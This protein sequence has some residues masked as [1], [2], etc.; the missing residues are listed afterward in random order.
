MTV[1]EMHIAFKFRMDKLD[2]LNY[3]DFEPIEIDLLLNQAQDRFV[4]QRYG[5]N[6]IKRQSFEESQKRTD[7]LRNL[8]VSAAITPLPTTS[9]NKPNGVFI[10]L[11]TTLNEEYWFAVNEEASITI[12]DCHNSEEIRRVPVRFIQHDD[13]N[14]VIYDP[15][16]KPWENEIIRLVS[17]GYYELI[18]DSGITIN[19]Y[20]LRYI[21]KPV[22]ISLSGN[23]DCIMSEHTHDE[24]VDEAVR[25]ALEGIEARRQQTFNN[26]ENT[27]E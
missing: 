18:S 3:P 23:V 9:D 15:F 24:I 20:Y 7:D 16:D 8:V 4:K 11:P 25:L 10:Q 17:D 21:K 19:T 2:S 1:S 26:I 27:N 13:Y 14:K 5:I 22:R 12:S 6:N